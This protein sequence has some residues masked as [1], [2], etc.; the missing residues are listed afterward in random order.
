MHKQLTG[1]AIKPALVLLGAGA[2]GLLVVVVTAAAGQGASEPS[3]FR[4]LSGAEARAFAVPADMRLVRSFRLDAYGLTY[5]RHQQYLGEAQV[6]GGQI[7]L[8][9]DDSGATVTVI[10]AHYPYIVQIGRAH[11]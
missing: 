1:G 2:V 10:G 5:E 9:R 8:Y 6:L 7:T 3:G 11:V 4:A